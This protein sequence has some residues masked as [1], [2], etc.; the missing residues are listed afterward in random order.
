[1]IL[2]CSSKI[3]VIFG[4][5]GYLV[6]WPVVVLSLGADINVKNGWDDPIPDDFQPQ[7]KAWSSQISLV[8]QHAMLFKIIFSDTISM[9]RAVQRVNMEAY[10]TKVDLWFLH[11]HAGVLMYFPNIPLLA[12]LV[13]LDNQ[14]VYD[15]VTFLTPSYEL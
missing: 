8:H 14:V 10:E 5:Y 2:C 3:R 15:I 4:Y 13:I 11:H 6:N 1:M 7:W 12:D 9:H